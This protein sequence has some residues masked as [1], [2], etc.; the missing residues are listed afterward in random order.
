MNKKEVMTFLEHIEDVY[1]RL[2]QLSDDEY[3]FNRQIENWFYHLKN[4]SYDDT[5][6]R[7]RRYILD[8][9]KFPPS[10]ADMVILPTPEMYTKKWKEKMEQWEREAGPPPDDLEP[11]EF[12]KR[13]RKK[14]KRES[15]SNE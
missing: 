3:R 15:G 5:R 12:V 2:F 9:N 4:Q 13:Y 8:G 14:K 7:L 1:P 10:V 6:E 11:P